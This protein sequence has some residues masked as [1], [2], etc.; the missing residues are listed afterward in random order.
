MRALSLALSGYLGSGWEEGLPLPYLELS[1]VPVPTT[2]DKGP[3]D[4]L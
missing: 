4:F 2:G 3:G 1:A